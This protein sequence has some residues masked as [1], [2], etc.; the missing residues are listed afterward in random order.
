MM[1]LDTGSQAKKLCSRAA[2]GGRARREGK[3]GDGG[4]AGGTSPVMMGLDGSVRSVRGLGGRRRMVS[5][6]FWDM[7]T[8]GPPWCDQHHHVAGY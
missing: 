5:E 6:T 3:D 2:G 1:G 4:G 8:N 7:E